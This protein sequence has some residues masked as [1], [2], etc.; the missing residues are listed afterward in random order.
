MCLQMRMC[1]YALADSL[2]CWVVLKAYLPY[3]RRI[4]TTVCLL[5]LEYVVNHPQCLMS[6][7]HTNV[8]PL[9]LIQANCKT[10]K[11]GRDLHFNP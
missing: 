2:A 10:L 4:V 7:K 5:L 3:L 8:L 11:L 9:Y 1:M 6:L